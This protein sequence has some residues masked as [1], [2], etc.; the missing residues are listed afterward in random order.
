MNKY[1]RGYQKALDNANGD[2]SKVH[3][4]Y[5]YYS[6]PNGTEYDEDGRPVPF[7]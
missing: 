2:E 1:N 6:S 3:Y 4:N 5:G 7:T